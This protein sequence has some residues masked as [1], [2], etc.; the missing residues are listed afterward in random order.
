MR[1]ALEFWRIKMNT[2]DIERMTA[3]SKQVFEAAQHTIEAMQDGERMQIKQLAQVV[4]L[5]VAKDPKEVLGF[6]NHFAHETSL[7]YVTRGKNGGIVKG[8]K[9]VKV[10]KVK[11]VKKVDAATVVDVSQPMID[12]STGPIF[13]V[14]TVGD[15]V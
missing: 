4:G 12:I 6:V 2:A 5:A 3:F 14:D 11:R 1:R 7:A 8:T 10:V 9:T 13:T 15:N